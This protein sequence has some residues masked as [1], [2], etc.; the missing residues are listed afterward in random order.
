M[1]VNSAQDGLS[2]MARCEFAA[3]LFDLQLAHDSQSL[4]KKADCHHFWQAQLAYPRL[5]VAALSYS[6]SDIERLDALEL[7]ADM[8][9]KRPF[10]IKELLLKIAVFRRRGGLGQMVGQGVPK[11]IAFDEHRYTISAQQ[12]KLVLTQTEFRLFKYLFERDGEVVTKEELQ[13]KVLNKPLGR[14]DRNLDMHISN[15]RRKLSQISLPREWIN[16]VR[17]QGYR[18]NA[19]MNEP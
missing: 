18:F 8:Y 1:W 7:G 14:F 2:E 13:Q 3:V 19:A 12:Q 11:Q 17:G 15:T 10:H 5:P 16:T 4:E 9:L 6:N